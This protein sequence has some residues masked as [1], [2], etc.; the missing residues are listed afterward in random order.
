MRQPISAKINHQIDG[1]VLIFNKSKIWGRIIKRTFHAIGFKTFH[2]FEDFSSMVRFAIEGYNSNTLN[3][4]VLAVGSMDVPEFLINWETLKRS[5]SNEKVGMILE[6]I[7]LLIVLEHESEADTLLLESYGS[8]NVL[9]VSDEI[10]L[11]A[12]KVKEVLEKQRQLF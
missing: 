5:N 12:W 11:N 10:R 1:S 9:I 4:F 2:M 8:E 7:G 3:R 6:D